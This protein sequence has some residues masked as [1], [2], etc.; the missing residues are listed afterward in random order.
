MIEVNL[1]QDL[2]KKKIVKVNYSG[3]SNSYLW[4]Y[5]SVY[6]KYLGVNKE[7]YMIG[8][9]RSLGLLTTANEKEK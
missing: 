6:G 4:F 1:S 8:T 7:I 3:S 2:I 9:D 5:I